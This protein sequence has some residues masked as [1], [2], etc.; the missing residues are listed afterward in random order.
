MIKRLTIKF[1]TKV[2]AIATLFVLLLSV[3]FSLNF[4]G[5]ETKLMNESL[6]REGDLLVSTLAYS[7]RLGIFAENE[8]LLGDTVKGIMENGNIFSVSLYNADGRLLKEAVREGKARTGEAARERIA[9]FRRGEIPSLVVTKEKEEFIKPVV[10]SKTYRSEESLFF[11]HPAPEEKRVIGYISLV[12]SREKLNRQVVNLI[13]HSVLIASGV[14]IASLLALYFLLRQ[15]TNPL[16]RL[17]EGV[18]ALGKEGRYTQVPVETTDEIGELAVAFN[19]MIHSLQKREAEKEQLEERLRHAAKMEAIGTLAGGV[20]HDFNNILTVMIGYINLIR[21][22]PGIDETTLAHA[23]KL[24]ETSSRAASLTRRLLAFSRKQQ[25]TPRRKDINSIIGNLQELLTRVLG[26]DVRIVF[27]Q[28]PQPLPVLVDEGQIDQ[29][30]INFATNARDAMPRGGTITISTSGVALDRSFFREIDYASPG[31]YAEIAF[32]D[33][34]TGIRDD[35]REKIFDP[36]FTTK[37]VG[38]GTG[39]GLSMAYG[40]VKQHNGFIRVE[41]FPGEGTTVKVYL[42]L[43]EEIPAVREEG[44]GY[45]AQETKL[46][47]GDD[48]AIARETLRHLLMSAGYGV[49]EAADGG[50]AVREFQENRKTVGGILLNVLMPGGEDAFRDIRRVAPELPI[51]FI[52]SYRDDYEREEED[53]RILR[54]PFRREEVLSKLRSLREGGE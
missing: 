22:T 1:R 43:V 8:E 47:V 31:R 26:E 38:K 40:I 41:S 23:E 14:L 13:L 17:T 16:N 33:T 4:I 42:P 3:A 10:M 51:F 50:E 24:R 36:F 49:I 37:E 44:E 12:L 15:V 2:F 19:G 25:I 45:L 32:S 52:G 53:E 46:L 35:I 29:V 30:L 28:A 6:A 39:L 11:A 48:D 34:G 20:A 27:N 5:T 7:T 9:R 18:N 21:K 54:K